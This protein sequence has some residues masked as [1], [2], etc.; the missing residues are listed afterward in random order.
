MSIKEENDNKYLHRKEVI[1]ESKT[2]KI[3]RAIGIVV[4]VL[5]VIFSW[6]YGFFWIVFYTLGFYAVLYFLSLLFKTTYIIDVIMGIGGFILYLGFIVLGLFLSYLILRYMFE[7]NFFIGVL[8]LTFG[9]PLA[10]MLFYALVMALALPL[11][12]FREQV[13]E[14]IEEK[15]DRYI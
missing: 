9:L 6:W 13:A 11:Y 15:D 2:K 3:F 4:L 10:E 1:E 14:K 5:L 8:L 7:E 12:Y